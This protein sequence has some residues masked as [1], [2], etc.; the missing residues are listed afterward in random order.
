MEELDNVSR[1]GHY[2]SGDNISVGDLN[3]EQ[4][5]LKDKIEILSEKLN[6]MDRTKYGESHFKLFDME[7]SIQKVHNDGNYER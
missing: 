6:G 3:V 7:R 4:M 5:S 2:I 1:I